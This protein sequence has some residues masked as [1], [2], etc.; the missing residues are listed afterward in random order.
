VANH[1]GIE[2]MIEQLVDAD[3]GRSSVIETRPSQQ[4]AQRNAVVESHGLAVEPCPC[5]LWTA[6]V[7]NEICNDRGARRTMDQRGLA[8]PEAVDRHLVYPVDSSTIALV[9]EAIDTQ[10]GT[11]S[12]RCKSDPPLRP[13]WRHR[14]PLRTSA[15][16]NAVGAIT[17]QYL[18]RP[19]PRACPSS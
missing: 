13:S 4:A 18:L 7:A 8:Q 12:R 3:T 11:L 14:H 9:V 5:V 2:P 19:R 10:I 16:A 1:Q 17:A 15:E 6:D